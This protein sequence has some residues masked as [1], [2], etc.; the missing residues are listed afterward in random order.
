MVEVKV[1]RTV[2]FPHDVQV[3]EENGE[4]RGAKEKSADKAWPDEQQ[5][6]LHLISHIASEGF[7]LDLRVRCEE[8]KLR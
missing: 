2:S 5:S 1:P 4:G 7:T 8:R 3:V 6:S